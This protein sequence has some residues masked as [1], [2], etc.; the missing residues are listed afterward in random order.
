MFPD[1]ELQE[2]I[3]SIVEA[4]QTIADVIVQVVKKIA[5]NLVKAFSGWWD[6]IL[7]CCGNKRIVYLAYHAKKKRIRK[8]NRNRLLKEFLRMVT[9]ET[10]KGNT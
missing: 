4:I 5:D 2:I 9:D 8:K 6:S 1:E 3:D 7:K 10:A